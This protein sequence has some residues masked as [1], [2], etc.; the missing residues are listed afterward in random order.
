MCYRYSG[1]G[2]MVDASVD[3]QDPANLKTTLDTPWATLESW[4]SGST[5]QHLSP[6]TSPIGYAL[7][8]GKIPKIGEVLRILGSSGCLTRNPGYPFSPG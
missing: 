1:Y 7:G 8:Y 5:G 3:P 2:R 4:I 6:I